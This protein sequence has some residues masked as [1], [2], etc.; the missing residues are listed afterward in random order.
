MNLL[1]TSPHKHLDDIDRGPDGLNFE[2]ARRVRTMPCNDLNNS[3]FT[4][5]FSETLS[6]VNDSS[7]ETCAP[8]NGPSKNFDG[9]CKARHR[10]FNSS[11]LPKHSAFNSCTASDSPRKT[12]L[13]QPSDGKKF[14][15]NSRSSV[16]KQKPPVSGIP[17]II[18]MRLVE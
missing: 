10:I 15:I 14:K 16:R 4:H 6:I 11:S 7:I 3:H 12:V 2:S 18:S 1:K 9:C 17:L 13:V 8:P 5:Q